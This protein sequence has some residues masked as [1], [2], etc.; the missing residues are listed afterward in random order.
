MFNFQT[1]IQSF[2]GSW[3]GG[4]ERR[5]KTSF[6]IAL[7]LT[8]WTLGNQ[9]SFRGI[10][11][12]FGLSISTTYIIFLNVCRLLY[13]KRNEYII[14]PKDAEADAVVKDF[15]KL[16]SVSF[17]NVIGC[18]DGTHIAFPGPLADNSFYNRKGYHSFILQA[19]CDSKLRFTNVYVGWP[20][21]VHDAKVW[22]NS[23]LYKK[24]KNGNF[25]KKDYHLLG[26]SAYPL[27]SFLLKPYKDDGHLSAQQINFNKILSSSRVIIEQAFGRLKGTFRRLK[28]LHCFKLST[29]KIIVVSC[30][31]LHNIAINKN[32][33]GFLD[34]VCTLDQEN[35]IP[36]SNSELSELLTEASVKR[37]RIMN[38]LL[39][40]YQN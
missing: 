38:T 26:D 11:D 24:L 22:T 21:S 8:L 16:R 15:E 4:R 6:K 25:I 7:L 37:D 13:A 2:E 35:G 29:I 31:I 20:G 3:I 40:I 14:W 27:D 12:R 32:E 34:E 33:E 10:S 23:P 5:S 36:C 1:L 17:P 39:S 30:C 18:I 28:Y 19:V 9:E